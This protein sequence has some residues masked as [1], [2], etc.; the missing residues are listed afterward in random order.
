MAAPTAPACESAVEFVDVSPGRHLLAPEARTSQ[1]VHYAKLWAAQ[2]HSCTAALLRSLILTLDLAQAV[3][4][5]RISILEPWNIDNMDTL[6]MFSWR[7]DLGID[8]KIAPDTYPLRH[9]MSGGGFPHCVSQTT[10]SSNIFKH[11]QTS[12][13]IFKHLQNIKPWRKW[14]A[15]PPGSPTWQGVCIIWNHQNIENPPKC[16]G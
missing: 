12:S 3:R 9:W 5:V 13:N 6:D 15:W 14:G 2:L 11:L 8:W 7:W 1:A 10:R 4:S 16:K